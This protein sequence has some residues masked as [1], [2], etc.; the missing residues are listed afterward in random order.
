MAHRLTLL[1]NNGN[2]TSATPTIR[3]CGKGGLFDTDTAR[4][5]RRDIHT[6]R[7]MYTYTACMYVY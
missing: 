1:L 4:G 2:P 6:S 3:Q 7:R 5:L